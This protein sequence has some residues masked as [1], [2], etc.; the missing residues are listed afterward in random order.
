[1]M[2]QVSPCFPQPPGYSEQALQMPGKDEKTS[3]SYDQESSE[4]SVD[5]DNS[6]GE[7]RDQ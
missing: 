2:P 6:D 1:M 4:D 7:E 5:G 3:V